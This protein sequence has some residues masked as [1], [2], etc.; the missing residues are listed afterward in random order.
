MNKACGVLMCAHVSVRATAID[1]RRVHEHH[2]RT[3]A[4][5]RPSQ[6]RGVF[7]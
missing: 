1:S 6:L 2:F 4:L 3:N 7:F 5:W